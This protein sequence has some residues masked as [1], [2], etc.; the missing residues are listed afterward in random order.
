MTSIEL[1]YR[2]S[3]CLIIVTFL[4]I[5]SSKK[6]LKRVATSRELKDT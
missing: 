6:F 2:R 1:Q 5:V 3:L 4:K